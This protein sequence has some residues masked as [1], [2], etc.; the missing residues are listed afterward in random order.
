[1]RSPVILV[2]VAAALCLGLAG[3]VYAQGL[4]WPFGMGAGSNT[5]DNSKSLTM[6]VLG[7]QVPGKMPPIR[8]PLTGF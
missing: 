7:P 8:A 3:A 2:L 5:L 1:M 4:T 6:M